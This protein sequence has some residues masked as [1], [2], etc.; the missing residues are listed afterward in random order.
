MTDEIV[1]LTNV[2][3]CK[4]CGSVK[5]ETEFLKNR[6]GLTYLCKDCAKSKRKTRVDNA[7]NAAKFARI[8]HFTDRELMEELARRGYTGK[9]E[10]IET[11]VIDINNM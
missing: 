3:Q 7:V 2:R 10:I 8:Q 6:F 1:T 11:H 5:P 4:C 9:L